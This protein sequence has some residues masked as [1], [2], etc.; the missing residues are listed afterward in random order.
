MG[1]RERRPRG[2]QVRIWEGGGG[3]GGGSGGGGGGGG[4]GCGGGGGGG[5]RG[6]VARGD[7]MLM[8]SEGTNF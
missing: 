1:R 4:G 6:G 2:K 5:G 7:G 3:G 8:W